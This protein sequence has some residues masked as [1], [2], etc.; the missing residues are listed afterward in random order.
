[1]YSKVLLASFEKAVGLIKTIEVDIST[2]STDESSEESDESE[3]SETSGSE[4]S[5]EESSEEE[6]ELVDL[7]TV[8][9]YPI[10][11]EKRIQDQYYDYKP[12]P[13]A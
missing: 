13:T 1:M 8:N 5:G 2:G 4:T 11:Y 12:L 3:T 6:T 9:L 10:I 7:N